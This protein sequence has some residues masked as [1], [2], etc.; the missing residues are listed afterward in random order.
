MRGRAMW[1]ATCQCE[2]LT[3]QRFAVPL[4]GEELMVLVEASGKCTDFWADGIV[5]IVPDQK[6]EAEESEYAFCPTCGAEADWTE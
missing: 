4:E 3:P 5:G 2:N 6:M 1:Q